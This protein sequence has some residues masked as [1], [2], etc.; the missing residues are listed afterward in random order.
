MRDLDFIFLYGLFYL[1]LLSTSQAP[2]AMNFWQFSK[3]PLRALLHTSAFTCFL[4]P[5]ISS[6]PLSPNKLLVILCKV[7]SF[8]SRSA[9]TFSASLRSHPHSSVITGGSNLVT[10][11]ISQIALKE[12]PPGQ[13]LQPCTQQEAWHTYLL[14]DSIY[15]PHCRDHSLHKCDLEWTSMGSKYQDLDFSTF[16]YL[17]ISL[18]YTLSFGLYLSAPKFR[19]LLCA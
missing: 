9:G 11:V 5:E 7:K 6:L 12:A 10:V 15:Q 18:C 19:D 13:A 14:I 2:S 8:P 17:C 4:L 3:K 16:F 1:C